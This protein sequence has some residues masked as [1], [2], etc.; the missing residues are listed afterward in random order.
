MAKITFNTNNKKSGG[1]NFAPTGGSYTGKT[2]NFGFNFNPTK[3]TT[4]SFLTLPQ[5]LDQGKTVSA[6]QQAY[7]DKVGFDQQFLPTY[8]SD[9]KG[10]KSTLDKVFELLDRP[11]SGIFTGVS[12]GMRVSS[13]F[14]DKLGEGNYGGAA[15]DFGAMISGLPQLKGFV[16]GS[17]GDR[18]TSGQ[19]LWSQM[20]D[21]PKNAK[22]INQIPGGGGY[23]GKKLGM[24]PAELVQSAPVRT[25]Y[26]TGAEALFDPTDIIPIGEAAKALKLDKAVQPATDFIKNSSV[27]DKVASTVSRSFKRPASFIGADDARSLREAFG[28]E[29]ASGFNKLLS[30][31]ADDKVLKDLAIDLEAR[32]GKSNELA[33]VVKSLDAAYQ[34]SKSG[35]VNQEEVFKT[36]SNVIEGSKTAQDLAAPVRKLMDNIITPQMV[37]AGLITE[38]V[39]KEGVGSYLHLVYD[40]LGVPQ[41]D[42]IPLTK[43]GSRKIGEEIGITKR[44]LSDLERFFEA[45]DGGIDV[46][47]LDTI[48]EYKNIFEQTVSEIGE[49][50]AIKEFKPLIEGIVGA[51]KLKEIAYNQRVA[52]GLVTDAS[53]IAPDTIEKSLRL[54][55]RYSFLDYTAKS[56]AQDFANDVDAIA[57]GF[58]K[59]PEGEKFGNLA[60]QYVPQYVADDIIGI[61]SPKQTWL[62]KATG[63]WK[64]LKLFAP[65]NTATNFR[66]MLSN[67][68]L[69]S[70]VEDGLPVYRLDIYTQAALEL[71]KGGE[72][73]QDARKA[74][75]F[76]NTFA[77]AEV[78]QELGAKSDDLL[79]KIDSA[80]DKFTNINF[81]TPLPGIGAGKEAFSY[82]EDAGKLAQFIYQVKE[83]GKTAEE[84]VQVAEE[85]LFN[86]NRLPVGMRSIRDQYIPFLSFRYFS[87]Q[88]AWD[89]LIN[90]TGKITAFSRAKR[91]V[92]GLSADKANDED[93]PEWM[94]EKRSMML[95]MPWSDAKGNPK[96]IDLTYLYPFGDITGG[97]EPQ[98]ILLGNPFLRVPVELGLNQDLY[99]GKDI[100]RDGMTPGQ[101][102]QAR[103]QHIF[104]QLGPKSPIIPFTREFDK[105]S[106]AVAGRPDYAGRDQSVSST[107]L[108]IFLGIKARDVDPAEQKIKNQ[109]SFDRS[110]QDIDNEISRIKRDQSLSQRQRD[111]QIQELMNYK[112]QLLTRGY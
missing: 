29:I 67:T 61:F 12:E 44:R 51:D 107:L 54:L 41:V 65:F 25:F 11:I 74:G 83:K 84:A 99:F 4:K 85:A 55:E 37:N 50:E 34:A 43:V 82:T 32:L 63:T 66:N 105:I 93:L 92:E 5:K 45:V 103:L 52:R 94:K 20:V 31:N 112:N 24:T 101:A 68:V 104:N 109:T 26:G 42:Q 76:A 8:R 6:K 22:M 62:T 40:K 69:N 86:Y 9:T 96:Y 111:E 95:R 70:L 23:L 90:R 97:F 46:P 21:D 72:M 98:D 36:V 10:K 13:D 100:V 28:S 33:D 18:Y 102:N 38:D 17:V 48:R 57:N 81:K 79:T 30:G 53:I 77:N 7:L 15:K 39:A 110:I 89:T 58:K 56:L 108:D 80:V 64:K 73:Y 27:F 1:F 87:A 2:A 35:L 47:Q 16:E 71:E 14:R 59:I 91:G 78:A 88:L 49:A 106:D 60:G 75:L 3:S 19:A